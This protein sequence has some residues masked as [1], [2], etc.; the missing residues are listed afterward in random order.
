MTMSSPSQHK[1]LSDFFRSERIRLIRYVQRRIEDTAARDSEDI[2]HDVALN[3][4]NRADV[5]VPIENI[6]AYVYQSLRN[7]I[8]DLL[9]KRKIKLI[10][11]EGAVSEYGAASLA[12]LIYDY[13]YN[14]VRQM[15]RK[16][17]RD[18]MFN[19]IDALD[20]KDKAIIIET[21]FEGRSYAE[22]SKEWGIPIGTLLARKS[23][24]LNKI[25]ETLTSD[26]DE[27]QEE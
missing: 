1:K 20:D 2:V 11:M 14:P 22:I 5:T 17:L 25:R 13:T 3:L 16:E 19:S 6:S 21:E 24:A 18:K 8:V 4:F 9:R 23:R 15:D 10:S 12:D 27:F 26:E 7:R